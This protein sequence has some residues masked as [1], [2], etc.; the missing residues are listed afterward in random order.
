MIFLGY[1]RKSSDC[2]TALPICMRLFLH[3]G[4]RRGVHRR[5]RFLI[6]RCV[7]IDFSLAQDIS[8]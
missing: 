5:R 4:L 1:L 6:R 2:L 7:F 3:V 8:L